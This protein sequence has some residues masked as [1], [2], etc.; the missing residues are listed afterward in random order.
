MSEMDSSSESGDSL[1]EKVIDSFRAEKE[2]AILKACKQRDLTK[3]RALAESH[4]G[5]LSDEI[6]QQAWPILLGIPPKYDQDSEPS[7]ESLP[8]HKDEDQVQLDVDRAFCY[9]P[10][11]ETEHERNLQ[12]FQ[13]SSLILSVLRRY[14][15]LHYFQGYH[16]ICQVLLLVLPPSLRSIALARLSALRIRDF[17]LPNLQAAIAQLRLIPD[18]LRVSDPKLWRHLSGTEPFFALSGTLT[19]YAHDITTLGEITRLFDVLLARE[20]V[21]SVYMFAAIVRSRREELFDTPEDEPEMLHS[22]L[23]K[24]PK[25]LNLE[26]LIKDTVALFE[27]YPPERLPSW[28]WGI[29]G[30]SVLKTA[31]EETGTGKEQGTERRGGGGGVA[32]GQTMEDGKRFFE[33]QV[34]ELMWMERGKKAKKWMWKNRRPV[35]TLGLAVLVGVIAILLRRAPGGPMAWVLGVVNRWW[36]R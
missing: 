34:R 21:F 9:Y 2:E 8:P 13:L 5:F 28:R 24:L 26:G 6:R 35:R 29:S 30:N 18:I 3:L 10:E 25:P 32:T 36:A 27:N 19:M 33:K 15:Y 14:P 20:P 12:K 11:H 4:G 16:D 22:I 7:W 31:R 1:H 23:S 17:M